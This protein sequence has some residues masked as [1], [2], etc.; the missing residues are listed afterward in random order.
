MKLTFPG[1]PS[2]RTAL[3]GVIALIGAGF[4]GWFLLRPIA[5]AAQAVSRQ[6][7][8]S[9]VMGTGTLEARVET[10]IG[11]K[12]AG[13]IESI[14]VD[15]GDRV[16]A[17]Q[18]LLRLDDADLSRQVDVARAN[19]A[20]AEAALE[21]AQ[22]DQLRAEV[23]LAA[24]RRELARTR[25]LVSKS[26]VSQIDADKAQDLVG[27]AEAALGAERSAV[28]EGQRRV[29]ASARNL[30][31]QEARLT[32]TVIKAPFPGLITRRHRESGDVLVPGSPVLTL[33]STEQ[34][35]VSAWADETEMGRLAVG[36]KARVVFRS[37]PE[38]EFDAA[39]ARLGREVDRETR[40]FVV[41]VRVDDLPR[42]W[43]IGQRAEVFV[44]VDRVED[45]LTVPPRFISRERG[46][47]GVFVRDGDRSRWRK[48]TLGLRGRGSVQVSEGLQ[49][50]QE[51]LE[52][53]EARPLRDGARVVVSR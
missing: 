11:S 47:P 16:E 26:V 41:D 53:A 14:P 6:A 13:R 48:V 1:L 10:S 34:L 44:A 8:V 38:R 39:V 15:Q 22:A 5:V 23:V 45:A 31:Y 19:K 50:G 29:T 20:A 46:E 52:P 24:A 35:W 42:N 33:I 7:I 36:Q 49:E 18:V 9:E 17:G 3:G 27:I 43:A 51:V 28:T 40:E 37:R 21:R 4:L 12:I 2:K 30:D 25:E 32:E